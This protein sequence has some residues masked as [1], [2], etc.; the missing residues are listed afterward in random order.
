[1]LMLQTVVAAAMG[2]QM[3]G[4]QVA[5]GGSILFLGEEDDAERD[6]R[7]GAICLQMNANPQLLEKRI[8]C[9]AAAGLDIRLTRTN[10]SNIQPTD[11]VE[12]II[13]ITT[14]HRESAGV[15]VRI[16]VFDHARLVLAGDPN[17]AQDV[18][19]LTRVLTYI[20]R[21]TGAAVFLLAHSPKS[22]LNKEGDEMNAAD[23]A[24]SSAFVDNS[25][26]TFMMWTMRKGE[27]K[28]LGISEQERSKYVRLENV[29]SN[30]AAQGGG[31]WLERKPIQDWGIS[32]LVKATLQIPSTFQ[33]KNVTNLRGRILTQL[34]KKHGGI[35]ER[36]LRDM[37]GKDGDL[38]ASD[39]KIRA[40][41]KKMLDEGLIDR[42]APTPDERRLHRLSGQVREILVS[43]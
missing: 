17:D 6:R 23:I 15:P 20:A 34:N 8:K 36:N 10:E 35:T 25:R 40:E 38:G 31:Y 4:I 3:E 30:Y 5:E 26:A 33:S 39:A 41:I 27:A 22:V 42:R 16:I 14:E 37:A 11:L 21:E 28:N 9:Y 13:Q 19:E 43:T 12:R 29:K 1:M 2:V 24:G 18:T 7:I 32:L